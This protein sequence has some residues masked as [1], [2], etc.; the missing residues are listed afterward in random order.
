M[1]GF[2]YMSCAKSIRSKINDFF[3]IITNHVQAV[4]F[5]HKDALG[6]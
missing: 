1:Y 4:G 6:W 5:K 3:Q 2:L